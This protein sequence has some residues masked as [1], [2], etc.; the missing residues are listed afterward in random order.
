MQFPSSCRESRECRL[1]RLLAEK[2]KKEPG[3]TRASL[4]EGTFL[5]IGL[6]MRMDLFTCQNNKVTIYEGK[7]KKTK[8]ID[9]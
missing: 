6:H 8:A 9:V 2:K 7:V 5:T 3:M 1:F 4:E